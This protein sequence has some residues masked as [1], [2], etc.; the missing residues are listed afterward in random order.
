MLLGGWG[1]GCV[2]VMIFKLEV[3]RLGDL[4]VSVGPVI[5]GSG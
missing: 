5:G 2:R 4:V 3:V 1:C